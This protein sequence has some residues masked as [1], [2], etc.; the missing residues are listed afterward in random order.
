MQGRV[1][2]HPDQP[3]GKTITTSRIVSVAGREITTK[4][5]SVY[6]LGEPDPEW[7]TYLESIGKPYDPAQPIRVLQK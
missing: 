1:Y 5:G 3:D 7:L 6:L 4:S 2:D